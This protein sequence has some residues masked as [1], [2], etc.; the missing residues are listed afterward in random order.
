MEEYYHQFQE[1][2]KWNCCLNLR[3]KGKQKTKKM[4]KITIADE[5]KFSVQSASNVSLKQRKCIFRNL[6]TGNLCLKILMPC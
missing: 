2:E 3:K 1:K 5:Q 4:S 6:E